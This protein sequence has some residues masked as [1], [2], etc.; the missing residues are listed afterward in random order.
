MLAVSVLMPLTAMSVE[1]QKFHVGL[2]ASLCRGINDQWL[3]Q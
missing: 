2:S 1:I 3:P